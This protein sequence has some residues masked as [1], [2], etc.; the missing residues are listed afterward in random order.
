MTATSAPIVTNATPRNV[1]S[2]PSSVRPRATARTSTAAVRPVAQVAASLQ[3]SGR[4]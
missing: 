4:R 3:V 2:F 1:A